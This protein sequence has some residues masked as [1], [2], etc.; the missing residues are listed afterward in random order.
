M[1]IFLSKN[2]QKAACRCCGKKASPSLEDKAERGLWFI[3]QE[4]VLSVCMKV[5]QSFLA[6]AA[7]CA[8]WAFFDRKMTMTRG[9]A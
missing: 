3:L 7:A 4:Q 5:G 6:A 8:F 2:A 1:V 9:L